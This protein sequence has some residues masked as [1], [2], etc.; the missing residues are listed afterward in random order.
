VNAAAIV[1]AVVLCCAAC[2]SPIAPAHATTTAQLKVAVFQ[3]LRQTTAIVD[4]LV[5]VRA[6][7]AVMKGRTNSI[8][9]V[10]FDVPLDVPLTVTVTAV[11][12]QKFTAD[13]AIGSDETWTFWLYEVRDVARSGAAWFADPRRI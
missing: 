7:G 1:V 8:G 12:Y 13:A 6:G 4:A 3:Y 9:E 5:E 10:A 2:A 11:G